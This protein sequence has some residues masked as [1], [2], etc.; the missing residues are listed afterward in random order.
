M[1]G[2]ICPIACCACIVGGEV[3]TDALADV[4]GGIG[5]GVG[6]GVGITVTV[7]GGAVTVIVTGGARVT[8]GV[9]VGVGIGA[10]VE[11]IGTG[12]VVGFVG[13][14]KSQ[15]LMPI[16]TITIQKTIDPTVFRQPFIIMILRSVVAKV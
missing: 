2:G 8:V 14:S 13:V 4:G 7:V 10:S 6:V 5:V 16:M 11:T 12:D 9:G 15:V 1:D 3:A